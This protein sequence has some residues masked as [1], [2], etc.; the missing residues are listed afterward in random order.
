[1]SR[2]REK[3]GGGH[4]A[5]GKRSG[6]GGV[7]GHEVVEQDAGGREMAAPVVTRFTLERRR[8]M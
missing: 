1:L 8:G 3:R 2:D 7:G 4:G 6:S 5:T